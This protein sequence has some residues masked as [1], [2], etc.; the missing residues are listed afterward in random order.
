VLF[1]EVEKA[2][3]EVL[4][5]LLQLLDDGRLTDGKG[6]TVDF[7]NVVVIMTSNLGSQFIAQATTGITAGDGELSEGVRRQV[8]EALRQHFRPEFINRIDDVIFFH[9]LGLEHMTH[10][11][12]IQVRG[13]LRRLEERKIHVELTD[14]AKG[15][16][17]SEGY[18]PMY[19]ARPLKRTIQRRVLDPLAMRV[20]EGE[21]RE[22]D[23]V[24]VDVS[25][26]GLSFEK[27][28]TVPA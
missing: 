26:D 4:N 16:L 25:K 27:K 14:P 20:L 3:A 28:Q 13:L 10:I 9:S 18:D 1:D 15:F 21:F 5:V 19:G 8:T 11:V 7:K 2:H 24:V 6:R 12:D 23:R 17:V 22:G